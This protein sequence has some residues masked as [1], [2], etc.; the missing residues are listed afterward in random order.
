ME[1][2][3]LEVITS[4][5]PGEIWENTN[6]DS[7]VKKIT[8]TEFGKIKIEG[9]IGF[10]IENSTVFD[11][12]GK[13]ELQRE[14]YTF[15]KAFKAYEDGKEIESLVTKFIYKKIDEKDSRYNKTFNTWETDDAYAHFTG[16]EIRGKWYIND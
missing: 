3:F 14:K 4:I 12:N 5:K 10:S 11:I 1:K 2:S 13:Y 15:E 16:R 9:G 7:R 6:K 8:L